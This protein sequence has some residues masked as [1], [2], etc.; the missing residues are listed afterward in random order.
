VSALVGWAV[1]AYGPQARGADRPAAVL[2]MITLYQFPCSH[3]CAKVRWALEYKGINYRTV[4]LLPGFH[5]RTMR[6]RAPRSSVP[7][8][9]H[10]GVVVQ[11]SAT[12]ISYLDRTFPE[13]ALTPRRAGAASE[14]LEW[15]RYLDAELGVML[16]L[17][18][19][20]QTLPDRRRTLAFLLQGAPWY[21]RPLFTAIFPK[22]RQLMRRHMRIDPA[23]AAAAEQRM[24][25]VFD[26]LE[27]ALGTQQFLVG[28]EFSRADLTAAALLSPLTLPSDSEAV[29][30]FAPGVLALRR[31]LQQRPLWSWA[32]QVAARCRQP[33]RQGACA[34]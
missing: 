33:H 28:E 13:A 11:Q 27:G 2:L 10:D 32:G 34:A 9:D 22:L 30:N 5:G 16:R 25:V 31:E 14:A 12:I 6:A 23:S 4:N 19:Y 18:F 24:R 15:E 3:F 21:A 29:R 8:L 7:V 17:W 20:H 26:R 1:A